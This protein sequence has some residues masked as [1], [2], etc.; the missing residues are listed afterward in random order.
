M[1]KPEVEANVKQDIADVNAL[2][3]RQTP[4]FFVNGKPLKRFGYKELK[5]L[6]E[7]EL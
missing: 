5:E 2:G 7:S 6:V 1:K 3:I 4:E